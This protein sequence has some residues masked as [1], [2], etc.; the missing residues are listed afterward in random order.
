MQHAPTIDERFAH[1]DDSVLRAAYDE[2]GSLV[3]SLCRRSVGADL[4]HDITQEVFVAAWR[5]RSTFD[6]SR[7]SLGAWLTGITK[8]KIVDVVRRESRHRPE[9]ADAAPAA[10]DESGTAEQIGLISD[11]MLLADALQTLPA[12]CREVLDLAF[13]RDLTHQQISDTTGLPLG[14]VKSDVRRGLERL[15]RY[16]DA[17]D[18]DDHE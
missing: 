3:Y 4:A 18:G 2:H 16:L 5:R 8:H 17:T 13:V 11:R 12:R 7:G 10:L 9:R 6:P 15:R 1:G 14:T